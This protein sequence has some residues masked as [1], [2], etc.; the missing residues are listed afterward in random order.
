M[1]LPSG[2]QYQTYL[3]TQSASLPRGLTAEHTS[4]RP[5][6]LRSDGKEQKYR[7]REFTMV[8]NGLW[9]LGYGPMRSKPRLGEEK[10]L[11]V[12]LVFGIGLF[13]EA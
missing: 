10:L 4:S 5:L 9:P 6:G 12:M 8:N 11:G 13:L 3:E 7:S 2:H 1:S